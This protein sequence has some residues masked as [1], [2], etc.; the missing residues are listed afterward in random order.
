MSSELL[1]ET[2]EKL[3]KLK[4]GNVPVGASLDMK[5]EALIGG[6]EMYVSSMNKK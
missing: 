5:V 2:V 1:P 3:K 4:I 6:Y